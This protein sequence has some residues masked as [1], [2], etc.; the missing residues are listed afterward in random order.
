MNI[1]HTVNVSS[2]VA[3]VSASAALCSK[4]KVGLAEKNMETIKIGFNY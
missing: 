2:I 4:Q 1:M 3:V